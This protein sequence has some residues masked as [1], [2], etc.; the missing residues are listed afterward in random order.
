MLTIG[1]DTETTGVDFHHGARV[2]LVTITT[3]DMETYWWEW[4]VNPLDRSVSPPAKDIYEILGWLKRS[5]LIVIQNS[6]FDYE[7]LSYTIPGLESF[8]DWSKVRDT[9]LNAHLLGSNQPKDL[10]TLALTELGLDISRYEAEMKVHCTKARAMARSKRPDWQIAKR[11]HPQMPSA[12]DSVWKYDAWLPRQIAE[13]LDLPKNHEWRSSTSTYANVDSGVLPGI[14]A[15]QHAKL[16]ERGLLAIAE[17]RHK[18]LPIIAEMKATGVSLSERRLDELFNEYTEESQTAAAICV[19]IADSVGCELTLPKSGSNK[20]LSNLLFGPDGLQMPV[21]ARSKKTEAPSLDK[22]VLEVY[23]NTL[24][25]QSNQYHFIKALK[26][27]RKRDTAL[28]YMESYRS[29]WIPVKGLGGWYVLFP[30]LNATGTDTLRWSSSNPNEQNISKQ[31]GFNLRYCFGPLP[32][33]EWWSLDANNIELRLPAYEAGEEEMIALFERPN[34]PPF[35]GSNHLLIF[36]ILH[37]DKYDHDDPEGLLKAKKKYASTWYQWTKNGNFAVQ[38]GAVEASGTA[39]RAYHV[40][41]GQRLIQQRFWKIAKLNQSLI[42]FANK[43][44]YVETM[45][46]KTVDPERGYPLL[47][48]RSKWGDILPTVPLNYHIQGTAMWWMM[49]AMIRVHKYLGELNHKAGRKAYTMVM[50]VHDEL[51]FDFPYKPRQGNLPIVQEI[52]RLMAM[53]G[54]DIGVPT[55]V[56]IEYHPENWSESR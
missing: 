3:Y 38:Y 43:T 18:I 29:F 45:P 16:Q 4:D 50:Q 12:K 42:D 26:N 9:L 24:P 31:E 52:A 41:G 49:K 14:Y 37:P 7:A 6:T 10:T 11:G 47:C 8:W 22:N 34:D 53:G 21:V 28:S 20:S 17:E 30:S 46:D 19:G 54:D 56:S 39:D 13:E 23:L 35:Y 48:T 55:P 27:K 5:D 36:S 25:K 32:G 1:L 15:S 51:V 40:P 2:Y 33:R 44:G